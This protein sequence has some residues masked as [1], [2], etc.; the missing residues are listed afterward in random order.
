MMMQTSTRTVGSSQ[1]VVC[2][3]GCLFLFTPQVFGQFSGFLEHYPELHPLE[4]MPGLI[5]KAPEFDKKYRAVLYDAPEIF[6]DPE[7]EY[8]IKERAS[9]ANRR[10]PVFMAHGSEDP[11]VPIHL[12]ERT[13]ATLEENGYQVAW[14]SYPMPH[15]VSPQEIA[16]I[17]S[18]LRPL[19]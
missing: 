14:H 10:V 4:N 16:D 18:W 5:W 2:A 13:V 12:A 15:S 17:G 1:L 8:K 11:V 19:L 9:E 3:L 6:L 7:S